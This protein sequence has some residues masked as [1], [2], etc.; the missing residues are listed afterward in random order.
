MDAD[1]KPQKYIQY[2]LFRYLTQTKLE[3]TFSI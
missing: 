2:S 3:L 1:M